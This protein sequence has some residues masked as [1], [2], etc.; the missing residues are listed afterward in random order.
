MHPSRFAGKGALVTGAASGI[1]AAIAERLAQEGA[2]VGLIDSR[3]DPLERQRARMHESGASVHCQTADVS[4][5]DSIT[6][7][8]NALAERLGRLDVLVHAAGIV[9]P[10]GLNCTDY[11]VAEFRKVVE[12]NLTGAFLTCRAALRHM[13]SG[14]YGRILLIASMA[15]K[16]G[17]PGM[18]GYVA[19]KAGLIGIAKALGK[20]YATKGIT[21]NALAPAV[22]ATPM[23]ADTHPDTVRALTEKIP[24]RRLGTVHEAAAIA[25]WICSEESSFNTGAVFDLSGGRATY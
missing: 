16:D 11:P 20:E 15:G 14:G 23:N 12:V 3:A 8:V 6:Y 4:E 21:V 19:S 7:A 10:T 1:G 22:I 2:A 13:L 24:M 17:N 18:A 9:G 25:C 5:D